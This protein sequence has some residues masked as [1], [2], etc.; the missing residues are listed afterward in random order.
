MTTP[1][2]GT[3]QPPAPQSAAPQPT[4]PQLTGRLHPLSWVLVLP[5]AFGEIL[6]AAIPVIL[7]PLFSDRSLERKL[8]IIGVVAAALGVLFL[9]IVAYYAVVKRNFRYELHDDELVIREG[10]FTKKVRHVP[11]TRIQAINARRGLLHRLFGLTELVL[12]SASGGAP[13]AR[14]QALDEET[15]AQL[16]ALLRRRIG[17]AAAAPAMATT[18]SAGSADA[19]DHR[20]LLRLPVPELLLHGF[21][22]NRGWFVLLLLFGYASQSTELLKRLPLPAGL[23]D[24]LKDGVEQGSAID[25]GLLI[26]ALLLLFVAFSLVLRLLSMVYSVVTLHGFTLT[27]SGEMLRAQHGLLTRMQVAARIPHL[28][29]LTLQQTWLHRLVDR[30]R[31]DVVSVGGELVGDPDGGKA[32]RFDCLAPITTPEEAAVLLRGCVPGLDLDAVG[33]QPLHPVAGLR[34]WMLSASVVTPIAAALAALTWALWD[35]PQVM[36]VWIV[37]AWLVALALA[38]WHARAWAASA[39]YGTASGLVAWRSGVLSKTTVLVFEERTQCTVVASS[40]RDRRDDTRGLRIDIQSSIFDW[41]MRIPYLPR[42]DA[43]ALNLRFWR[44]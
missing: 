1:G 13:E 24:A 18:A 26:G 43:E 31:I 39:A 12:E 38:A 25:P 27:R 33:W 8:I 34:R 30:C 11:F 37:G 36:L 40:P 9:L 6:S 15:A 19:A 21:V 29:R 20:T 17:E 41:G 23:E 10:V 14:L 22:S 44:P 28:Q 32:L 5:K 42:I 2:T 4:P 16:S 3:P 35:A 7:V